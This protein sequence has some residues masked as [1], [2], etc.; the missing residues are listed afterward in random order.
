MAWATSDVLR[1]A[2]DLVAAMGGS[3]APT[4]LETLADT[5]EA[6]AARAGIRTDHARHVAAEL[7]RRALRLRNT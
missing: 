5:V 2:S 4:E 1:D 6:E 3:P 7:R